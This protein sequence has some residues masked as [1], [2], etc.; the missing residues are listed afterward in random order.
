MYNISVIICTH[1]PRPD[2]LWRALEALKQQTL[3]KEKWELLLIDNASKEVLSEKWILSW[4]PKARHIRE[5]KLG[6][7]HA[8]MRAISESVGDILDFY[9]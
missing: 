3:P 8:R 1:N 2:Y 6:L 9:R 7:S 5:E 4:H